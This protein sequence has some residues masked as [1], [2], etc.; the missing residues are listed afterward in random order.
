MS[1]TFRSIHKLNIPQLS[2]AHSVS[3]HPN[4]NTN[5]LLRAFTNSTFLQHHR[6][7]DSNYENARTRL[8]ALASRLSLRCCS[9]ARLLA[10]AH[11]PRRRRPMILLRRACTFTASLCS[12]SGLISNRTTPSGS[13]SCGQP[14]CRPSKTSSARTIAGFRGVRQSRLGFNTNTPTTYGEL[15]TIFEFELFGVGEHA[16][17]TTFR[18]AACLGRARTVPRRSVLEHVR[19]SGR[20]SE[21]AG[22]PDSE[23]PRL[24]RNVQFR[25][26]PIHGYNELFI[27]AR[28]S[29]CQRRW[30]L[31]SPIASSCRTSSGAFPRPISLRT[32][33]CRATESTCRSPAFCAGSLV[34]Y[35]ARSRSISRATDRLG[36][37]SHRRL[38][39]SR[40]TLSSSQ[41]RTKSIE[42]YMNYAP[43]T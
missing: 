10:C 28:A 37:Q 35:S 12:I 31:Y 40:K 43:S 20:V 14:N 42:N 36:R 4:S 39:D 1:S 11:S 8:C 30:R 15:K 17:Q 16:S 41:S 26:M 33:N 13:T 7:G 24:F 21:S 27:A 19:G 5:T 25:C 3:T 9:Q 2:R 38:Q 29:R 18:L 6:Q 34:L 23:R 32:T 22:V